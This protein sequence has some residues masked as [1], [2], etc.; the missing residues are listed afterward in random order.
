LKFEEYKYGL[1]DP[2][3]SDGMPIG[4]TLVGRGYTEEAVLKAGKIVN[5][6]IIT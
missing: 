2:E 4:L 5:E 3:M 1:Y 6:I